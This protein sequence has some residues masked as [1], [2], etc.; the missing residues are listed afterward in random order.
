VLREV[1]RAKSEAKTSMRAEVASV[2]VFD[3]PERLAALAA[4]TADLA[5]AGV[6]ASFETTVAESFS[7]AV[8]LADVADG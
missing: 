8:E 4:S 2:M 1:R 3:S 5:E 7:V 6:I